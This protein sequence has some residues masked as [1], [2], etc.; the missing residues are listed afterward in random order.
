MKIIKIAEQI[1]N[2][3]FTGNRDLEITSV[4]CDSR[5]AGE[6]SLFFCIKGFKADGHKFAKKAYEEGARAF[7]IS[8]NAEGVN[9]AEAII[10]SDDT[11][12]AYAEASAAFYGHPAEKMTVT[13]VTGTNGKTTV[14]FMIDYIISKS[15]KK[16]G[17][18]GTLCSKY[19]DRTITSSVTTPDAKTLHKT[20]ADMTEN[21]VE[22]VVF[23]VSSHSLSLDRVYGIKFDAAVFTNLTQDHL[24]FHKDFND[25]FAAKSKL[26]KYLKEDGYAIVNADDPYGKK[27]AA[28]SKGRVITYGTC[29]CDFRASDIDVRRDGITYTLTYGKTSAKVELGISGNFNVHNSMAAIATCSALGISPEESS[30]ILRGFG[31]VKGRF[32]LVRC[33]QEFA[34]A[35]DYAHT[36][37]GLENVLKTAQKI[38]DGK[39]IA[40]F[41]CGGDRD[42]TK[43]PIMGRIAAEF[44]DL[45]IITSDN[46]R[47]EE[48]ESIISE[49]EKGMPE[50]KKYLKEADRRKAIFLA[51]DKAEKGDTVVI[52]GK[53][54]ENYQIFKNETIHFDDAET[55]REYFSGRK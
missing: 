3:V 5:E 50:G 31:G 45:P 39:V 53:G 18:I 4:T 34:V 35:V 11:R 47:T 30:R 43:R 1:K 42:R 8:D 54:H 33:G 10:L 24:D 27:I 46:P 41:G 12:R 17:L 55:A 49:I 36:P 44:A 26:F 2:A 13:G 23:E 48:P 32:E 51:L 25:Y 14:T 15:G 16:S 29:D 21:G 28:E 37:D 38:T 20:F 40:V 7:C 22:S 6:G 9:G 52:A 19:G